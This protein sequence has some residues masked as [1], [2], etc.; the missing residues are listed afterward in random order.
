MAFHDI[1]RIKKVHFLVISKKCIRMSQEIEEKDGNLI[2][3]IMYTAKL[4]AYQMGMKEGYR[5]VINN[6]AHGY[7]HVYRVKR[8]YQDA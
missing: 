3:K 6:G 7:Q 4:L 1:N 5:V 8:N 2:G